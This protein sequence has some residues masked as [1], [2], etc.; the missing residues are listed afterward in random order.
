VRGGAL[1]ARCAR[2]V[3]PHATPQEWSRV[4]DTHNSG[5]YNN[6]YMVVDLKRFRWVLQRALACCRVRV[7]SNGG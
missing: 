3:R 2:C 5:T 1:T 7:W 4:L 6:Q